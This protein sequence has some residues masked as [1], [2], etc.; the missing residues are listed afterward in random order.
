MRLS[1]QFQKLNLSPPTLNFLQLTYSKTK[2]AHQLALV[3]FTFSIHLITNQ[4]VKLP[5]TQ[6][7]S[8]VKSQKL[9]VRFFEIS[10]A[11]PKESTLYVAISYNSKI[12]KR[13]LNLTC[14]KGALNPK[15]ALI[16]K[17]PV[18]T[19]YLRNLS[20]RIRGAEITLKLSHKPVEPN[21]MLDH[22]LSGVPLIDSATAI[23]SFT[24]LFNEFLT[25]YKDFA[26]LEP[27]TARKYEYSLKHFTD[28][29]GNGLTVNELT[30]EHGYT[31]INYLGNLTNPKGLI[32]GKSHVYKN[33]KQL[34]KAIDYALEKGYITENPFKA[35]RVKKSREK[36]IYALSEMQLSDLE[37]VPINDRMEE[38]VLDMFLFMV[39][40]S[41]SYSDY[42]IISKNPTEYIFKDGDSGV[43]YF[44]KERFKNRKRESH[45]KQIIRLSVKLKALLGKYPNGLPFYPNQ[46]SNRTIK[47]LCR[48]AEIK[49]WEQ[50]TNTTARKTYAS[51]ALNKGVDLKTVADTLGHKSVKTTEKHYAANERKTL[52]ENQKDLFN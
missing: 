42:R 32:V 5:K 7:V 36:D 31:L 8:N 51:I 49:G 23:V 46:S 3:D 33:F 44:E 6:Q 2:E 18:G 4:M 30:K 10:K 9:N 29:F 39:Y 14:V 21:R 28:C 20:V 25:H 13:S 38:Q 48:R 15:A 1:L 43:E 52:L 12:Y 11:N 27:G 17:D 34:E 19:E 45:K 16:L 50:V 35:I 24:D 26:N 22:V 37:N 41:L 47:V 40:T